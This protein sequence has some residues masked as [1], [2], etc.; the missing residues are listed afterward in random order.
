MRHRAG[1]TI[2]EVLVVIAIMAMLV[3]MLLPAVQSVKERSRSVTCRSHLKQLGIACHDFEA[4]RRRY[5]SYLDWAGS[6]FSGH[7]QLLPHVGESQ[8][9]SALQS[10]ENGSAAAEPPSVILNSGLLT[11]P[12]PLLVC[13]SDVSRRVYSSYRAC[14]GTTPG[15]H[16]DW[17]P[18]Q[19]SLLN[20]QTK[21]LWGVLVGARGP[22]DVTDGL[23]HTALFSER[24]A[25]DGNLAHYTPF[26]DIAVVG[27]GELVGVND[28]VVACNSVSANPSSHFSSAGF[29]WM[30]G[31]YEHSA[32]NHILPPNAN[33]PDCV[34]GFTSS[35][36][37]SGAISARSSHPGVVMVA[38]ADGSVRPIGN[39]VDLTVWRALATIHGQEVIGDY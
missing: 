13:P 25:G 21:A 36:L 35:R 7:V 22:S 10:P 30:I 18:G 26:H 15:I 32:Y 23:S 12:V 19:G 11:K 20:P 28:T 14:F 34:W 29:S 37:G 6:G 31:T 17:R 27:S 9:F 38:F 39:T 8:V 16:A 1:I 24:V 4:A 33:V 5:P 3:A 2:V